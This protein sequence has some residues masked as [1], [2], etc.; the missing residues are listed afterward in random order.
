MSHGSEKIT[1]N[2]GSSRQSGLEGPKS[3]G[4][5]NCTDVILPS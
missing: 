2:S 5:E 3:M 1:D 4:K